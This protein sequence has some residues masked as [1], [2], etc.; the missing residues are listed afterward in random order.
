MI[1]ADDSKKD[2]FVGEF[3]AADG[4]ACL[5]RYT[6]LR[7]ISNRPPPP[8]SFLPWVNQFVS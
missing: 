7:S 8:R 4:G 5:H 2:K 6:S 3:S 1:V